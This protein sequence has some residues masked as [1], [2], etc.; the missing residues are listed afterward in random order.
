MTISNHIHLNLQSDSKFDPLLLSFEEEQEIHR[1]QQQQQQQQPNTNNESNDDKTATDRISDLTSSPSQPPFHCPIHN[2]AHVPPTPATFHAHAS[3]LY[4]Q[5]FGGSKLFYSHLM[6]GVII[7]YLIK[8]RTPVLISV[9]HIMIRSA[10]SL[11]PKLVPLFIDRSGS[12]SSRFS[13][14]AY[15]LLKKRQCTSAAASIDSRLLLNVL[16]SSDSESEEEDEGDQAES[17]IEDMDADDE[18]CNEDTHHHKEKKEDDEQ[19]QED[20]AS[21]EYRR[22]QQRFNNILQNHELVDMMME[23]Y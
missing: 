8:C 20:S 14:S 11:R 6:I 15:E 16:H 1:H 12:Y 3:L 23:G 21:Q 2:H 7:G 17:G 22:I 18:H 13:G 5:Y 4:K 10:G 9:F 19:E